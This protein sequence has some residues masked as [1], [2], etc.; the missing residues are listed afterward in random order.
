MYE[1]ILY[2][3]DDAWELGVLHATG[4]S[5]CELA[6]SHAYHEYWLAGIHDRASLTS[7]RIEQ[8]AYLWSCHG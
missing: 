3:E 2:N 6:E 7:S 4:H 5:G 1:E 8:L